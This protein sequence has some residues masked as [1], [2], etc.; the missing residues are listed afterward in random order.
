MNKSTHHWYEAR[1]TRYLLAFALVVFA[2]AV[3]FYRVPTNPPGFYIDE[4][5]IAYNAH[6]ISLSGRDEYGIAWPLYF[7]AFGEYKNPTLVYLLAIVFR[8]T[9]PSIFV[10]RLVCALLGVTAALLLGLLAWKISR[11]FYVALFIALSAVLTPWLFESSRLVFEVAAYPLTVVL[12]LLALQRASTKET[13]K[14]M[15]VL[16]LAATLALLTYTYSIGRLLAPLLAIGLL[17][18]ASKANRRAVAITIAAHA[19]T[20]LPL[21][22]FAFRHPGA[23]SGRFNGISYFGAGGSWAAKVL[24]FAS[25]YLTDIN[26]WRMLVT[27]EDNVRDHV[28]GLGVLLLPTFV[29]ALAGLIL[30]IGKL[31]ANPWWRFIVYALF[32][33]IVPAALTVGVFPQLRL[34]VFPIL[35]NVLMIPALVWFASNARATIMKSVVAVVTLL[36]LAQ[37]LY[38]QI[39]F[40][41]EAPSHWYF[42]DARFARKVLQPAL[43]SNAQPIYLFDP[44]GQSG[45]IQ[46]L[47]HG[48]LRGMNSNTFARTDI[49]R[50]IAPGSI[51]ISTERKCDNCRLLARSLNYI[52]YAVLPSNAQP[53]ISPLPP[54]AFRAQLLLRQTTTQ[55][56]A[57]QKQTLRV[58]V[59]N[60]SAS[61]WSCISDAQGRYAVIIRARWRKSDG[62][63][64]PDEA[65][66]E[67]NYDLEPGDVND[68][69]LQVTSPM[70]EGNYYLE[71]DLVEEPDVWFSQ[72]GSQLLRV[73]LSIS[74]T[75]TVQ[76]YRIGRD[77]YSPDSR[78]ARLKAR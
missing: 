57:G 77:L 1:T 29:F 26:P 33:S 66:S 8:F 28:S 74:P 37:G 71:V 50:S 43:A 76:T 35:V 3:Y 4:S 62:S 40:H 12:F 49:W 19:I 59:K 45:Y 73:P 32:V 67:L 46:A 23:L 78:N 54:E 68:V 18:F 10:A 41:R 30:V 60:V 25:Q 38:F 36:I 11:Q 6:A 51:V 58:S 14:A 70:A 24:R 48:A 27:G 13:W 72:K 5:S 7:R 31:R 65:R 16:A 61:S 21:A 20:L 42:M 56:I 17:F 64:I 52:A 9:G 15:D 44:P 75:T 53:S 47:W 34:I 22:I 63:V 2:A 55:M 69:D 39:L